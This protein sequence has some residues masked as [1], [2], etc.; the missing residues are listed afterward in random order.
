[1]Q[2]TALM[3]PA[4]TGGIIAAPLRPQKSIRAPFH[5]EDGMDLVGWDLPHR[6][7]EPREIGGA[8]PTL[9][10]HSGTLCQK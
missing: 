7:Y 10:G 6:K 1:M 3:A 8:S 9:H 2:D 4:P 5:I